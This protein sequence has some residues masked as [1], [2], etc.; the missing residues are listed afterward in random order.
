METPAYFL[1]L[2]DAEAFVRAVNPKTTKIWIIPLVALAV[3]ALSFGFEKF[4]P[5]HSYTA[6]PRPLSPLLGLTTFAP[7]LLFFVFWVL[8]SWTQRPAALSQKLLADPVFQSEHS[9]LLDEK[10]FHYRNG[11]G[12][13]WMEWRFVHDVR[14]A[15]DQVFIFTGPLNGHIVPKRAFSSPE[16]AAQWVQR[17]RDL[18][19]RAKTAKLPIASPDN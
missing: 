19:E 7:M 1:T 14:D 13:G 16:A 11:T 5:R 18:H 8:L 17:A 4:L 12:G 6:A 15:G 3:F 2:A 9:A 10:A